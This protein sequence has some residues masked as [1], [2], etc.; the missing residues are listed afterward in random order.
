MYSVYVLVQ[1]G[2]VS[3]A[4]ANQA[5]LKL[6]ASVACGAG[7]RGVR[8]QRD[9]QKPSHAYASTEVYFIAGE[10]VKRRSQIHSQDRI[11]TDCFGRIIQLPSRNVV[12]YPA[13]REGAAPPSPMRQRNP[14]SD[15][16]QL[17]PGQLLPLGPNAGA[18]TAAGATRYPVGASLSLLLSIL[19]SLCH[20]PA[21]QLASAFNQ[22]SSR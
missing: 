22:Q 1:L 9:L 4:T 13:A 19:P 7:V 6:Q 20:T 21:D 14:I 16:A 3:H 15:V 17:A 10:N 2:S 5:L 11:K 12:D 8:R 18:A